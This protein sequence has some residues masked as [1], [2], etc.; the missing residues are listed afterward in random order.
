MMEPVRQ[1]LKPEDAARDPDDLDLDTWREAMELKTLVE[2]FGADPSDPKSIAKARVR[3]YES[4][5]RVIAETN[6]TERGKWATAVLELWHNLPTSLNELTGS[7]AQYVR[8]RRKAAR[9]YKKRQSA[10]A[11]A[12]RLKRDTEL[13]FW[14]AVSN[15]LHRNYDADDTSEEA[16][17]FQQLDEAYKSQ[18]LTLALEQ[19]RG[20][21]NGDDDAWVEDVFASV[22]LTSHDYFES[23]YAPAWLVREGTHEDPKAGLSVTLLTDPDVPDTAKVRRFNKHDVKAALA[24]IRQK[25][26]D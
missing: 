24:K 26:P 22:D 18:S 5:N 7:I 21:W 2:V 17:R 23:P 10:S 16:D 13:L 19:I 8:A 15:L 4:D 3:R 9:D 6:N 14:L 1:Y 20:Y 12:P 25:Y 11:S